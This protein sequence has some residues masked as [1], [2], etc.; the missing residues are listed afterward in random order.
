MNKLT[1]THALL[2]L[3]TGYTIHCLAMKGSLIAAGF[4]LG[5]ALGAFIL[6]LKKA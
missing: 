3:T 4:I 6:H 5:F 2:C 1:A